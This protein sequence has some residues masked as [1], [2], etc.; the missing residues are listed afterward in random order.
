MPTE[1]NAKPKFTEIDAAAIMGCNVKSM[2]SRLVA[3]GYTKPCGRC[4][5]SGRYSFNQMTGDRCFG[6]S[7]VGKV[8]LPIT[9]KLVDAAMVRIEAGELVPYFA[10]IEATRAARAAF[11][12]LK[13]ELDALAK[14]IGD[15]CEAEYQRVHGK[16]SWDAERGCRKYVFDEV[17]F[18]AQTM[19]GA[20][21][22]GCGRKTVAA[23]MGAFEIEMAIKYAG[24]GA[25]EAAEAMVERV[26]MMLELRAAFDAWYAKP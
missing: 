23:A 3:L 11:A 9:R 21:C 7:G 4:G 19:S 22:H 16:D 26:A 1:R 8:M 10:K 13:A 5:G 17:L 18:R 20:I 14:P 25:I 24:L 2:R 15:R 12:P 6:C